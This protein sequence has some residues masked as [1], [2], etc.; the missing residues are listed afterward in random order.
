MGRVGRVTRDGNVVPFCAQLI[1]HN[2][3]SS[4]V[5]FSRLCSNSI[6]LQHSMSMPPPML[7]LFS[8]NLTGT[9]ANAPTTSTS[10]RT[11]D[12]SRFLI[13]TGTLVKTTTKSQ[14]FGLLVQNI[15]HLPGKAYAQRNP[16]NFHAVTVHAAEIRR[17]HRA[18]V[19]KS[20]I[21]RRVQIGRTSVCRILGATS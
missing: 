4:S 11:K 12:A 17:L 20:E 18:G 5:N 16:A 1:A 13:S 10:K 21:D 14:H 6:A 2:N 8:P 19:S 9:P 3:S 7:Q 15:L